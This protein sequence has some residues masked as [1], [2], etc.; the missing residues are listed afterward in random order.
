MKDISKSFG[1]NK[2]AERKE[3]RA[4]KRDAFEKARDRGELKFDA[5]APLDSSFT[6]LT[7]ATAA[8]IFAKNKA[9]RAVKKGFDKSYLAGKAKQNE[10][11]ASKGSTPSS[12]KNQ[13]ESRTSRL[14]S[15]EKMDKNSVGKVKELP[16]ISLS[17]EL[18]NI[19]DTPNATPAVGKTKSKGMAAAFSPERIA[20]Y[21]SKGWAMDHT[22]HRSTPAKSKG[23][24]PT[25]AST[26]NKTNKSSKLNSFITAATTAYSVYNSFGHPF[27]SLKN[28]KNG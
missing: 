25:S 14:S 12:I 28:K 13:E 19:K 15:L 3:Y 24:T 11:K 20:Q 6:S 18:K 16:L 4:A 7:A 26:P 9:R 2:R 23:S 1:A 5:T 21:K 8:N 10:S 22:T 17:E 27:N